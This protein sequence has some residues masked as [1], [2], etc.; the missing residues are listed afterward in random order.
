MKFSPSMME[1][2]VFPSV[3]DSTILLSRACP[4]K[5]VYQFCMGLSTIE[6]SIHLHAGGAFAHGVEAVRKSFYLTK[7]PLGLALIDG[8]SPFLNYWC[9]LK[10]QAGS[11]KDF[12]NV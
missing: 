7:M 2:A 5:F 1:K 12:Y 8:W 6:K 10:A 3:I 11:Y 9:E 4:T